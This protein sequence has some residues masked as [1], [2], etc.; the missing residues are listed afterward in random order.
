M[1]YRLEVLPGQFSRSKEFGDVLQIGWQEQVTVFYKVVLPEDE[2]GNKICTVSEC[3]FSESGD[4]TTKQ[5]ASSSEANHLCLEDAF[6]SFQSTWRS[7]K[8]E[9]IRIE[10]TPDSEKEHPRS[11]ASIR[12][13]NTSVHS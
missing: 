11:M 13:A 3:P 12:R 8:Q 1:G 2:S 9:L 6:Q 5:C 4:I 7:H 10:N